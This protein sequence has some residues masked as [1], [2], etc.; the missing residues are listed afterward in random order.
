LTLTAFSTGCTASQ[1][2]LAWLLAQ[3]DDIIPIPGTTKTKY[4]DE[5]IAAIHLTL[6]KEEVGEI[7]ATIGTFA[8]GERVPAAQF[9]LF[10][11]T[12][13]LK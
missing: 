8:S 7:R 6:T 4:L 11:D 3:G 9:T 12:P 5:N 2:A 10:A 1:L 13:E